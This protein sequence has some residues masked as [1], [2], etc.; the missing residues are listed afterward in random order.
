MR[1]TPTGTGAFAPATLPAATVHGLLGGGRVDALADGIRVR[2]ATN[3]AGT[4]Y[5]ELRLKT[6]SRADW[7][8]SI[9]GGVRVSGHLG[10]RRQLH[11]Q[12]HPVLGQRRAP[13]RAC[14]GCT[15]PSRQRTTTGWASPTATAPTAPGHRGRA[16]QRHQLPL[17]V[18]HR[19]GGA[20]VRPGV[21]AAEADHRQL[22]P[23]IP[24][25]GLPASTVRP[26]ASSTTSPNTPWGVTGIVGANS[27]LNMEVETFAQI[28]NTMYVGGGFQYVQ[29]GANPA[30]ADKIAQPWLAG[31][32]VNTGEWLSS[33][34]PVLN[35]H[36]LG[37]A[38]HPGRQARR[39]R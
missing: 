37:P 28:G 8:W 11:R 26:L 6:T 18:R 12:Q 25:G 32:D 30:P 17:A 10:R 34:R 22:T 9:G 27:E 14:S 16:E 31:F 20:A 19:E 36:G 29:K 2:R 5:Q 4:T 33:F 24:A 38:G 3:I 23:P 39:R 13:R 7:T 35:A 15:P 1:N 21:A